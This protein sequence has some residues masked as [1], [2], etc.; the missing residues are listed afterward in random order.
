MDDIV[1]CKLVGL[2]K[3]EQPLAAYLASLN[4]PPQTDRFED[5]EVYYDR[6]LELGMSFM[7]EE[8]HEVLVCIFLYA[9]GVEGFDEYKGN[10]PNSLNF[11]QTRQSVLQR[12]GQPAESGGIEY[13]DLL[14]QI[15]SPWDCYNMENYILHITYDG[16][17]QEISMLALMPLPKG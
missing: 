14:N 3:K 17:T 8:P 15:T 4:S 7:F 16:I 1:L 9:G 10:L 12:L 2:T 11:S 6:Y 13:V 5:D